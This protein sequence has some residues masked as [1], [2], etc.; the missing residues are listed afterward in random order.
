MVDNRFIL[1]KRILIGGIIISFDNC[2]LVSLNNEILDHI[3]S[4]RYDKPYNVYD[5]YL[6]DYLKNSDLWGVEQFALVEN[7]N[8]IAYVS[9]Q[10]IKND[11]W[12]GWALRPNLCG[13]G[14]G[15]EFVKKCIVELIALKKHYMKE[16]FLKVYS[17]NTRA[18]KVYKKVG[19]VHYDK[20]IRVENGED[21]EYIIMKMDIK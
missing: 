19:F 20:F 10:V 7:E 18:I 8:I 4:W 21:T 11:M 13:S 3:F 14:I 6:N 1:T 5:L 12:V 9:C 2:R 15:Q 17:W 16:I